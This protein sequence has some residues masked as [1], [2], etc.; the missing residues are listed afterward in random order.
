MTSARL[1]LILSTICDG[2]GMPPEDLT[3]DELTYLKDHKLA[4]IQ[5]EG[6][7]LT[8]AIHL[9]PHQHVPPYEDLPKYPPID[10]LTDKGRE[11]LACLTARLY[12][13]DKR[14]G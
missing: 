11:K 13:G 4:T 3:E 6:G 2:S 10:G 5:E 1:Q 14:Y 7:L 9:A 8:H 12:S